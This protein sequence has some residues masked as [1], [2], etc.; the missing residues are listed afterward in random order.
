VEATRV[1]LERGRAVGIEGVSEGGAP[2]RVR[3]ERAV[4]LAASAIQTPALLLRSGISHGPVGKHFQCHPGVSMSGRFPEPVR[5]W[6][7]ATQGHEVIGLRDEGLKFEALGFD[8]TILASRLDGVGRAFAK[9]IDDMAHRVDW[10]VA[11]KASAHG[12]VRLFRGRPVVFFSPSAE[13]IAR[14]RRGLR[15]MGD[16]MLAAGAEYVSPGVRGYLPRT[17]SV[18]ELA[19]LERNGPR[20][21]SAFTSAITHMFGTCRMGSDASSNVVR[22]DFR[23]HTVDGLYVAD[24]SVFPTN[25]GVNPQIPVMTLATLCARRALSLELAATSRSTSR[26]GVG[27]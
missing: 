17:S 20:R 26:T 1:L 6:E 5:M 11:V 19:E 14:F 2:V 3:A 22:P 9:E 24:S 18:A 27:T 25:L 13:D 10:G 23:H 8:L 16:M 12:R 4:I 15:V 21:A 7:G